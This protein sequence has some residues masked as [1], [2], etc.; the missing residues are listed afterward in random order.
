MEHRLFSP[1][2]GNWAG[3]PLSSFETAFKFI[4]TTRT[5]TGL[6][7]RAR[8]D[9]REYA[10]GL[11]VT[12]EQKALVRFGRRRILQVQPHHSAA[13]RASV[14]SKLFSVKDLVYALKKIAQSLSHIPV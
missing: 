10:T 6:R 3:Q 12:K 14:E 9:T 2:G 13:N 8:L 11:K 4:R 5:E 1:I 7:C